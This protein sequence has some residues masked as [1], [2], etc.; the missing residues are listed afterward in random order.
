MNDL[1][2][3]HLTLHGATLKTDSKKVAISAT[4]QGWRQISRSEYR[5]MRKAISKMK[6]E[7]IVNEDH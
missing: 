6:I 2:Q 7:V 4:G 3:Y 5:R 1:K